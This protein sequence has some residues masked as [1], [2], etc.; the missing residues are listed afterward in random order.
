MVFQAF[1][2]PSWLGVC[3]RGHPQRYH[4]KTNRYWHNKIVKLIRL[5]LWSLYYTHTHSKLLEQWGQILY[6]LCCILKTFGFDIKR[7]IWE[8]S[9]FQ[10]CKIIGTCDCQVFF[11][12]HVC[13]ITLIIQTINSTECRAVWY[14][15]TYRS[16]IYKNVYRRI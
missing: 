10:V 11:A 2:I 8:I 5:H 12:V 4:F 13:P 9:I 7:W 16:A 14:Y 1:Y 3:C 15:D 6:F